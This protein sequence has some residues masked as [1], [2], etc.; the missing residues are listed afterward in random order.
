MKDNRWV[1]IRTVDDHFQA[2]VIRTMLEEHDIRC[3]LMNK[4][5]SAYQH[6]GEIEIFVPDE[7]VLLATHLLSK[8]Q[9]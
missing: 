4:Q 9:A 5:M 1:K 3:V 6:I 8:S 7:Q 2:E